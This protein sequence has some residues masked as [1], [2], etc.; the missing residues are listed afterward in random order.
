[1]FSRWQTVNLF[2][3]QF[4]LSI[5]F[6]VQLMA[7]TSGIGVAVAN[8]T[9][10]LDSSK[11]TGNATIFEGNVLETSGTASMLRL[12]NGVRIRLDAETRSRLYHDRALLERGSG[13][14]EVGSGF[15]V[16]AG[17]L[18]ISGVND[19]SARIGL[20]GIKT[21]QIV[22]V[23]G[24]V[25]VQNLF[26]V[27]LAKVPVGEAFEFTAAAADEEYVTKMTGKV[28]KEGAKYFL[29]DE[30]SKIQAELRGDV[31]TKHAGQRVIVSGVMRPGAN[32]TPILQVSELTPVTSESKKGVA[33]AAGAAG[34]I[35]HTAVIAGVVVAGAGAGAAVAI[36]HATG[37][38]NS[39]PQ[40][41]SPSRP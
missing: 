2:S 10:M 24:S 33:G 31:V 39:D 34:G 11:V 7:G 27:V 12:N 30:V 38:H 15:Q 8:G 16:Q 21:V 29:E 32:G 22:A 19:S 14:F 4:L 35:S 26:G 41:L 18:R 40:P 25:Q 36:T 37:S 6:V 3:V 23:Q 28:R 20:R 5:I 17:V 1:M 13:T 9:F